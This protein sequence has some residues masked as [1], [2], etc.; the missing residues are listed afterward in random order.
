MCRVVDKLERD[1][2]SRGSPK[3]PLYDPVCI[4]VK[5]ASVTKYDPLWLPRTDSSDR[6][7]PLLPPQEKG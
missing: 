3:Y 4:C 2:F 5:T 1:L 7:H 6:F